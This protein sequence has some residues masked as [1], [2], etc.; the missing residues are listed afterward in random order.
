MITGR[1]KSCYPEVLTIH[2]LFAACTGGAFAAAKSLSL[3]HMP[4]PEEEAAAKKAEE[5][6]KQ[7]LEQQKEYKR[8][9][10]AAQLK[11]AQQEEEP[12]SLVHCNLA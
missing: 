12:P 3:D 7:E 11:K 1:L 9:F 2:R 8:L 5:A 6:R 10:E 4:S